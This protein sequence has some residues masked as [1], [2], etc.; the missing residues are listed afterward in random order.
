MARDKD[1]RKPETIIADLR[2]QLR[3]SHEVGLRAREEAMSW[4]GRAT[5]AEQEA[6]DWR[7]RYDLL[8]ARIPLAQLPPAD[9]A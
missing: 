5:K 8:L 3:D 4:R 7:K 6:A 9:P 2:R 1:T